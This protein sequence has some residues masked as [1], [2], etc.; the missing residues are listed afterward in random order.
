MD[1]RGLIALS[2]MAACASVPVQA[3]AS[4][5]ENRA[6]II[7]RYFDGHSLV[8]T[9]PRFHSRPWISFAGGKLDGAPGCG[10]IVGGTYRV[11][12]GLITIDLGAVVLAGM[13]L[14]APDRQFDTHASTEAIAVAITGVRRVEQD[15][16]RVFLRDSVGRVRV[17]LSPRPAEA[18]P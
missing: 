4:L 9:E 16:E 1:L 13:C 3:P 5:L 14:P 11:E 8:S 7:D 2:T 17:V 10:G 15:N 6:W 18:S 12:G